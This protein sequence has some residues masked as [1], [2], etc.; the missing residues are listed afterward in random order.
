M[1]ITETG[2]FYSPSDLV[3]F[4]GCRHRT[5]IDLRALTDDTLERDSDDAYTEILQRLG[6]EHEQR[7]LH[8]L[9]DAG[10]QVIEIST[11]ITRA[12]QIL[13]TLEVLKSGA[14]VIFQATLST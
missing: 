9:K 7:Y 6:D 13:Q 4:L 14:E 8:E 10:R 1:Q 12:T 3:G 2:T 5:A 11:D